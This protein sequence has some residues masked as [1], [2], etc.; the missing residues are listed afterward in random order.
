MSAETDIRETFEPGPHEATLRVRASSREQASALCRA[1]AIEA[2][3]PLGGAD[4]RVEPE[5]DDGSV[6]TIHVTAADLVHLRAATNSFLKWLAAAD[7]SLAAS[8]RG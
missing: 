2:G 1:L 5:P 3:D 7:D 6:F 8:R 4:V